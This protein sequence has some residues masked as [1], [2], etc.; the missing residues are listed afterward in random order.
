[1]N[2]D[3]LVKTE[4]SITEAGLA[5]SSAKVIPAGEVV[6]AT[7]VGLGKVCRLKRDTAINQDLRGLLPKGDCPLDRKYLFYWYKSI[8]ENV[9]AAGTGATVQGVKLPFLKWLN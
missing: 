3:E 6:I 7:R 4:H 9:V 5:A 2:V 1:M 8:S